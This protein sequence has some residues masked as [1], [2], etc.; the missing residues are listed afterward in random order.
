MTEMNRFQHEKSYFFG[1]WNFKNFNLDITFSQ[2]LDT[3]KILAELPEWFIL[4]KLKNFCCQREWQQHCYRRLVWCSSV[5]L[6][7]IWIK[8]TYIWKSQVREEGLNLFL[9][10]I[11]APQFNRH[12]PNWNIS[13]RTW[14]KFLD[15]VSNCSRSCIPEG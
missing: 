1:S 7:Y 10:Q 5:S 15:S 9:L 12:A 3:N 11:S 4:G 2:P 6:K 13:W 14:K 8:I